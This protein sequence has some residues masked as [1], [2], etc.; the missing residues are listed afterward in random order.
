MN[1][2]QTVNFNY[3]E[4][5]A[6]MNRIVVELSRLLK[7]SSHL[8]PM[9]TN[10]HL[11]IS[12]DPYYSLASGAYMFVHRNCVIF[13]GEYMNPKRW[14]SVQDRIGIQDQQKRVASDRMKS[15]FVQ[16]PF[17]LTSPQEPVWVHRKLGTIDW[18]HV[19]ER[20]GISAGLFSIPTVF[21]NPYDFINLYLFKN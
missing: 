5:L 21:I 1:A 6:G 7:H 4:P 13:I 9:N 18:H 16:F 12:W 15:L 2:L 17:T 19:I 3:N 10:F 11:T 8:V 14:P 20:W